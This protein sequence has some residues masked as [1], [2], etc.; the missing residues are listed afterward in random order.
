MLKTTD[1]N[2]NEVSLL[3]DG[4]C[5]L[6][7]VNENKVRVLGKIQDRILKVFRPDNHIHYKTNLIGFNAELIN[8]DFGFDFIE[9]KFRGNK[10]FFSKEVLIE[11]SF[12]MQFFANNNELQKFLKFDI[13]EKYKI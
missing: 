11:N 5:E 4:V 1:K 7:L 9:L 2:G 12:Y 10:Y 6:K 13:I 8:N 3:Y